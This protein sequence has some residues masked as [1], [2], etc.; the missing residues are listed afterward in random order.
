MARPKKQESAQVEIKEVIV[1]A[2]L[3]TIVQ[4][5]VRGATARRIAEQAN[6]SPGTITYHFE[7]ID[8]ILSAA[9]KRMIKQ[10]TEAFTARLQEATDDQ[11]AREAVVDLICGD[12]WAT[13]RHMLLSF[14]L[15]AFASRK[16]EY[17]KVMEEWME[18]CQ[19]ALQLHFEP[20]TARALDAVIEGCT[21]HKTLNSEPVDRQEIMDLI[22]LITRK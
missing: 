2:A 19:Q 14:E 11:S 21:I 13:P 12:V 8:E 10:I 9:F 4:E 15:Y 22:T 1:D 16:P 5:G 3:E 7:S 20:K 6:L 18:R 17:R